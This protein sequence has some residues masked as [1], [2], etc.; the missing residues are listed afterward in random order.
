MAQTPTTVFEAVSLDVTWI[1]TKKK[2]DPDNV[3]GAA[4]FILDGMVAADVINDDDR[5]H[6]AAITNRIAVSDSRGVS[7][8]VT[9]VPKPLYRISDT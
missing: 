9:S 6:V 4:K 3:F 5:D 8:K 1:E 2:R 7:V